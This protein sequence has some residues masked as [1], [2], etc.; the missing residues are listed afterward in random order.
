M[1]TYCNKQVSYV[2]NT[3]KLL[4]NLKQYSFINLYENILR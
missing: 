3:R 1:Y 2:N 4:K